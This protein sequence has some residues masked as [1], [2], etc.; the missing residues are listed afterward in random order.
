MKNLFEVLRSKEQEIQKVSK[1]VEALRITAR[2]LADEPADGKYSRVL[3]MTEATG[4][5]A[6][7]GV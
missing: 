5:G 1:E 3:E 4:N 2:L 6:A 7:S